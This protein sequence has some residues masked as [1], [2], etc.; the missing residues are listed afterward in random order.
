MKKI[1]S[2]FALSRQPLRLLLPVLLIDL[3]LI[4]GSAI[5]Q[6]NPSPSASQSAAAQRTSADGELPD[7]VILTSVRL[8]TFSRQIRLVGDV[9]A[10]KQVYLSPSYST[11]VEM[12]AE[13]GAAVKKNATVARLDVKTIEED[14]DEQVLELEVARSAL[15]EHDRTTS[16]DKVRLDAEIQRAQAELE[17][18]NLA[19]SQ[20]EAGTRPEEMRKLKLTLDQ[21]KR[22]RELSNSTLALK[23]KLAAKGISTQLEVLQARQD[24]T[25]KDRDFRVAEAEHQQG[26]RGATPLA[27][28]IARNERDK[29][30]DQV[31]WAREN[32]NL[33]LELAALNRLKLVAKQN[34]VNARVN[35][36]KQQ[37]QQA[38]L[39]APING[40]VVL[41]KAWTNEGLK[42]VAVGDDVQEGSPI[43]TIADLSAVVIKSEL[44]ETL[45]RDVKPGMPV[46]IQLPSL[47]GRRFTGKVEHI[48]VLAHEVSGRQNTAG[49]NQVFDLDLAPDKQEAVFQPGTSVDIQLPLSERRSVLMLPRRAIWRDGVRH[50][51][52]LPDGS[53]RDVQLGDANETDVIISSGLSVGDKVRIPEAAAKASG[54]INANK[55]KGPLIGEQE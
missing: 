19:L 3:A 53:E 9:E 55:E 1:I 47:R 42:R 24:L 38:T 12:L 46:T 27:R 5:S 25:Q 35:L 37:M 26:L 6:S 8:G 15:V 4:S 41:T 29:A 14:L 51:V 22:A 34:N 10:R 45:L 54:A 44:D 49:L 13:D 32:R 50:Y 28:Q 33:T 40:T 20:L 11:K 48:G 30:R 39:K 52:L 23:E 2:P 43:M 17:Q 31:S 7:G 18:K 36:L 16:A 21:A